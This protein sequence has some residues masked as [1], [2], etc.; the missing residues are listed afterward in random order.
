LD[1]GRIVKLR[2]PIKLPVSVVLALLLAT[3]TVATDLYLPAL[4]QIAADLGGPAGRVQWTLTVFILAFGL[5][6]LGGGAL[7]DRY[8]RRGTL[9]WGL[10]LYVSA[11]L[12]AMLSTELAPLIVSRAVQGA[13][14]ATCVI[15]ARA[16]IRDQYSG[17]AG[18]GIMARSMTGMSMI[19]FLSP[20]LGGIVT[21]YLGWHATIG[22]VAGF[23]ALAWL[24]VYGSFTET[25]IRPAGDHDV[26][27]FSF[28]RNSQF[29]FSSL[30]AGL[31]FSGAV[32][33]LLLSPFIF[34][35]EFGMSRLE[36]GFV[37]A[38][39]TLAFLV[40]TVICRHF[41]RRWSV[42]DVVRFGAALS[43][44]GGG[45]Q[46][47]LWCFQF[48]TV[49]ALALPQCIYMMG[50][51]F[52]QPCGQGGAVAPFPKHAGRAAAISGF[53]ITSAA[54]VCGQSISLS[55]RPD[56]KILV[57]VMTLLSILVGLIAWIAIPRAYAT[58]QANAFAAGSG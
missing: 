24:V 55:T 57:A 7:V 28:F 35:G 27:F 2:V 5:A 49:W 33:F 22:A 32:C 53:V 18:L 1:P 58:A 25:Y 19:G 17:T 10:G 21:Q 52:H 14:T 44:L 3:Q 43:L 11:G 48:R 34:I 56:S 40:G 31:S 47:L 50:H 54:F 38:L 20:L 46:F 37:P 23:G 6:Q 45:C 36:Y 41:L 39:C 8:G 29:L 26:R 42:P 15:G 30:L 51:G 16:I 9:L 13:A 12:A 4:P